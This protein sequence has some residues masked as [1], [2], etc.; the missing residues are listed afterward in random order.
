ML[1]ALSARETVG[2]LTGLVA[3]LAGS[4]LPSIRNAPSLDELAKLVPGEPIVP[5]VVG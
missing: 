2:I 5:E 3:A 1:G 4:V